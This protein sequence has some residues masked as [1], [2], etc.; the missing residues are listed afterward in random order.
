MA[1]YLTQLAGVAGATTPR[2]G[3]G[4]FMSAVEALETGLRVLLVDRDWVDYLKSPGYWEIRNM[5]SSDV[6]PMPLLEAEVDRLSHWVE[7]MKAELEKMAEEDDAADLTAVRLV[8][9][10]SALVRAKD[11][12]EIDWS[13]YFKKAPVRLIIPIVVVMELDHLKNTGKSAKARPR[14]RKIREI[15]EGHGKGPAPVRGGV[16]LELLLDPPRHERLSINDQEIIRRAD[17][18]AERRGGALHIVTGDYAMQFTAEADG[19]H[20]FFLPDELR[21]DPP[22]KEADSVS[23]DSVTS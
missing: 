8:M 15:L 12:T 5:T 22:I 19:L 18:F 17:F 16:T 6:R 14:L 13:A 1:T 2:D 21:L 20:V 3:K 11:F 23:S 10:T 4:R 7:E 9:D